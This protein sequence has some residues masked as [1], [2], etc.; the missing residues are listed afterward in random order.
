MLF[1]ISVNDWFFIDSSTNERTPNA[2][3]EYIGG[4]KGEKTGRRLIRSW[5]NTAEMSV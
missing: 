1:I 3:L 2:S 5:R 4:V